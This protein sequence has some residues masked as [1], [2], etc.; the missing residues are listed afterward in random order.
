ME[1]Q[2]SGTAVSTERNYNKEFCDALLN[3]PKVKDGEE[4]RLFALLF[5]AE[6]IVDEELWLVEEALLEVAKELPEDEKKHLKQLL[7]DSKKK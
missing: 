2:N 5:I 7:E 3:H 1:E 4:L 6:S